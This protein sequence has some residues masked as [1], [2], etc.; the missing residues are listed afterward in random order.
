V[1]LIP[2]TL[3]KTTLR[4]LKPGSRINLEVD[5]LA[6]YVERLVAVER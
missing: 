2:H 6:R 3:E 5:M 1:N 4:E